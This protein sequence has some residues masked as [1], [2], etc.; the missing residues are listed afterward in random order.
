MPEEESSSHARRYV[1]PGL[2]IVYVVISLI[3]IISTRSDVSNLQQTLQKVQQDAKEMNNRLS[4]E[5][6]AQKASTEE[7]ANRLGTTEQDLQASISSRSQELERQQ[8]AA[9]K[10]LNEQQ[11][12]GLT[13]VN[14]AVAGVKTDLGSTQNDLAATKSDLENT[15]AKLERVTGDLG[16]QSGL[17]ARTRS[18]LDELRRRGERNYFEFTLEK[19]ARPAPVSTISL[20]LKKTDP[21][22]SRFTLNVVADDRVIEKRDRNVAEPL[23]FYTGRERQLYEIV[24]MSVDKNRVHGYLS[25]PKSAPAPMVNN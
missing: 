25:T 13:Q 22:K 20:Q 21:K 16:Q 15:K 3:L 24:V 2:A 12:Q 5:D 14:G 4:Q 11:Q 19:G 1:L 7:L 17:I 9:E 8:R 23:Q 10:R 18:D 6:R